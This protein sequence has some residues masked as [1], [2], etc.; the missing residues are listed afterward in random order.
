MVK[1]EKAVILVD[2]DGGAEDFGLRLLL[3]G[4]SGAS[5]DRVGG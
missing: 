1:P 5:E 3:E 4:M 2:G